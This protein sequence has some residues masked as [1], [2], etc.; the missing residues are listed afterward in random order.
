M[1]ALVVHEANEVAVIF[2]SAADFRSELLHLR[3]FWPVFEFGSD[4]RF[5]V[6]LHDAVKG[7]GA[8]G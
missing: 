7:E 6:V 8:F 2:T 4:A 3:V 1:G 5:I